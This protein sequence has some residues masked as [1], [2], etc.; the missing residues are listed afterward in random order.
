[1]GRKP[2]WN[3]ITLNAASGMATEVLS[4]N[5]TSTTAATL[6]WMVRYPVTNCY[7]RGTLSYSGPLKVPAFASSPSE[8]VGEVSDVISVLRSGGTMSVISKLGSNGTLSYR[9]PV[10][11]IPDPSLV[12]MA[13]WIPGNLQSLM[14]LR[15]H[16]FNFSVAHVEFYNQFY[17]EDDTFSS[18]FVLDPDLTGTEVYLDPCWE[19][20]FSVDN[21]GKVLLGSFEQLAISIRSGAKLLLLLDDGYTQLVVEAEEIRMY[22]VDSRVTA[23]SKMGISSNNGITW[24][25]VEVK[26]NGDWSIDSQD[27]QGN[28]TRQFYTDTRQRSFQVTMNVSGEVSG[29]WA[30][31]RTRLQ[32]GQIPRAKLVISSNNHR[33]LEI[34]SVQLGY[35]PGEVHL[36]SYRAPFQDGFLVYYFS[37]DCYFRADVGLYRSSGVNLIRGSSTFD[38]VTLFFEE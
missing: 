21:T 13:T 33:Y 2:I 15:V 37:M 30:E 26:T 28:G 5:S 12:T 7:Q 20:Q 29:S 17:T 34:E 36:L 14:P 10:L 32:S 24:L 22:E 23:Y 19:L 35:Q 18:S 16:K 9:T 6:I 27:V 8:P 31:A 25:R 4:D 38:Q 3:L 11:T 1:M